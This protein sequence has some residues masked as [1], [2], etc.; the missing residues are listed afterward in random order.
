MSKHAV[1]FGFL[2]LACA[3]PATVRRSND[4]EQEIIRI[5]EAWRQPRISGNIAFLDSLYAK[6]FRFQ[7]TNGKVISR[8]ADIAG[9]ASGEIRPEVIAAEE[10]HVALYG[11]VAVVTGLDRL[12]G[13]YKGHAGEGRVRF[14]DVF[15]HRA[16]R[17]QLVA[18]QGLGK[19]S[20]MQALLFR[21]RS[22]APLML[23]YAG[24]PTRSC[25]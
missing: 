3:P 19:Q 18:I 12:K 4:R 20:L 1:L 21:T 5:E 7:G 13:S 16:G 15:V 10:M 23:Y 22:R 24:H 9:F 25:S 2:L 11:D 8:K 6:E 17:W 14:M